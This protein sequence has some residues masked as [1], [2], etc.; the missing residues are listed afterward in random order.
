MTYKTILLSNNEIFSIDF[1][2]SE[3]SNELKKRLEKIDFNESKLTINSTV[4]R[5]LP[6]TLKSEVKC[7]YK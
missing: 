6:K 5:D 2:L 1:Y 7:F 3:K 4:F